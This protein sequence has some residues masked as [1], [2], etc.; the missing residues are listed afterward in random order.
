MRTLIAF[1]LTLFISPFGYSQV[2]P[3]KEVQIKTAIL[4]A[5]EEKREGAMVYGYDSNGEFTV[6]KNGSNEMICIAD[7]PETEGFSVAAYPKDLEAF[8]A[9]GRELK[10]E[11]KS[12]QEIFDTREAEAKSGT[13]KMPEEGATLYV[14]TA[15]KED[16]NA[17]TGD[18]SNTYLRYVV[19]IPWSTPET[20]GLPLKPSA[21]GMPWIMDPGTHRAH[22]MITPP[23]N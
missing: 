6:L 8:M 21:P 2:I 11:G 12:F 17:T 16:F 7:N 18:V 9:R 3:S 1:F 15:E 20:T 23:R 4:A 22:I 13:L 14:L 10:K 5:P 19:Y